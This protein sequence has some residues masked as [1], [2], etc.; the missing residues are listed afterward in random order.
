M[1][2]EVPWTACIK[3]NSCSTTGFN[4]PFQKALSEMGSEWDANRRVIALKPGGL[5]ARS[6][7]PPNFAYFSV[8]FGSSGG[9]LA[10]VIEDTRSFPEY[11][12]RV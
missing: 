3:A 4:R 12:G 6:A 8:E 10:R 5:G 1:R 9:G 7:I 11:F 2:E